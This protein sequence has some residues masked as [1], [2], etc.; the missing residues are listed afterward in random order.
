MFP[1]LG[2]RNCIQ[3][4]EKR[5]KFGPR[6]QKGCNALSSPEIAQAAGMYRKGF[7]RRDFAGRGEGLHA[8]ILAARDFTRGVLAW[9]PAWVGSLGAPNTMAPMPKNRR[10]VLHKNS[11]KDACGVSPR[12]FDQA[13]SPKPYINGSNDI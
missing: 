13:L 12:N 7:R 1:G 2:L 4:P 3:F 8:E 6:R 10:K 11:A 5:C 9:D